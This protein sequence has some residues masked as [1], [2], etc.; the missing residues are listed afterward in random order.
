M[1]RT[2]NR[3]KI[4]PAYHPRNDD[5]SDRCMVV[6]HDVVDP[7]AH[8]DEGALTRQTVRNIPRTRPALTLD[9]GRGY[10]KNILRSDNV[11]RPKFK[12]EDQR[13]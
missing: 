5:G 6:Q 2:S 13:Q 1:M 8:A 7:A 11:R 10:L 12:H 9:S 3:T 4:N